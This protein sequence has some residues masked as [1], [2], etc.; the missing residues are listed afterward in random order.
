MHD[1]GEV[2]GRRVEAEIHQPLGNVQCVDVGG[3]LPAAFGHEFVHANA[4]VRDVVD[5]LQAHAQVVGVE[6]GVFGHLP[7]AACTQHHDI[8][9][10][11]HHHAKVPVEG[12]DAPDALGRHPEAVQ[13]RQIVGGLLFDH[14]HRPRQEVGEVRRT[15][16]RPAARPAAA[17]GRGEGLVQVEVHYIE[18]Q[19][20]GFGNAQQGVQVCPIAVNQ[21]AR[22][23]YGFD[24]FQQMLLE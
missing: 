3:I 12:L 8:G 5:I 24:D 10:R 1:E 6:H 2:V 4:V 11:L 23:V 15:D 18:A 16:H 22:G 20:A 13:G 21:P 7:Q 14:H 9:K 17:V 19:F